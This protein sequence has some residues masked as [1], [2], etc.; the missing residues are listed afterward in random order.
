MV[1]PMSMLSGVGVSSGRASGPAVVVSEPL[2]E[3][4]TAP[5]PADPRAEAG[6]IAPA[7]QLVS[8]E[9]LRRAGL[10]AEGE[11]RSILET[12]AAMAQDPTLISQA[13][14]HVTERGLPASRAVYEAANGFAEAL[15]ATGGYFAERVRDV[16]DI[17]DRIIAEL[18]GI[19]PPGVP[20][21]DEP[22]VLLA[23]D[24]A[25][26]DTAGL[27][28][29]LVLAIATE[30]GGPT[31]HTAI[32]AR[33]LGIP[34]V[35]AVRGLLAVAD[36]GGATV[37]GTTGTVEVSAEPV[38]TRAAPRTAPVEWD[39]D[40]TLTDGQRV[41]ILANIGSLADARAAASSRAHGVGLFRTEFCFLGATSEPEVAAQQAAYTEIL[42]QFA[43]KPVVV[44]TLDAGADKP[45][46][47]LDQEAEP[48]PALGVRGLR[49]MYE[50]SGLLNRQLEAIA[51][52]GAESGASVS[53]MAPMV[54]SA[55]EATW[56]AQR[57]RALGFSRVGVMIEVPAAALRIREILDAVDFVSIGTNDLAQY[58][59]AADRMLGHLAEF[60]DPWQPALLDLI[61][62]VGKAGR[63]LG[64]PVGI[65]GEA[66]SD[67]QLAGVHL[68]LGATSLS[69]ASAAVP[70]VAS[71][72]VK[73]TTADFRRAAE[74][75]LAASNPASARQ[76]V[77]DVL[78]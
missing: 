28:P 66:A 70:E 19:A 1:R 57:A 53:V 56:F 9:L 52:A 69:M 50:N 26:A 23:R 11:A 2:P 6:R 34:A 78:S 30:E 48:N 31:S 58:L 55:E 65:C 73:Y 24:L 54:S 13:E 71:T 68:G 29:D 35:V 17:R 72:L 49:I 61:A 51:G 64:K 22:S 60:N 76:A 5:A 40:G 77:R 3:P 20:R 16:Q 59:F 47:F 75:A 8:G 43:G 15:Q 74:A 39:G 33:S 14:K 42:E 25:P 32:L 62:T 4:P 46:P 67:P 7:A 10:N 45:L 27:D 63:E 12:T 38:P 36:I 44:R 18:T 21:F 41:E 37:D